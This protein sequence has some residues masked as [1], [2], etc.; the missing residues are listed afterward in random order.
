MIS[1][2]AK[3][4]SPLQPLD[5]APDTSRTRSVQ[6]LLY[7]TA[8]HRYSAR[9]CRPDGRELA[10]LCTTL[11]WYFCV[12]RG[13][14]PLPIVV[15]DPRWTGALSPSVDCSSSRSGYL[16][17]QCAHRGMRT[18]PGRVQTGDRDDES[19]LNGCIA[20]GQHER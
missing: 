4:T 6:S 10:A 11:E 2:P 8:H 18:F 12:G 5:H 9:K 19:M 16:L 13:T 1:S 3:T 14:P 15:G 20:S 7:T 17:L